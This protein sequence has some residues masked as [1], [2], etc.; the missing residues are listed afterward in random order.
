MKL[1]KLLEGIEYTGN[2]PDADITEV[3]CNSQIAQEGSAFVC[4]QGTKDD[5]HMHVRDALERGASVVVCARDTG[6]ENQVVV[7]DTREAY[8]VMCANLNGNPARKLKLIGVTGTNGKTT[9]TY[10]LKHILQEAGYRVGV[11]GTIH[12]E[13]GDIVLPAKH[14]TPDPAQ[15]HVLFSRMLKAG[16]QYVVME[17]SSHALDQERLTGCRFEAGIFTNLT[18]DHLDYHGTMENYFAAK[19]KLFDMSRIAVVNL[20]DPYGRRIADE[21]RG[22]CRVYT[23][24]ITDDQADFTAKDIRSHAGGSRFSLLHA[25]G[26]ERIRFCMPGDFSV[27]N[28]TAAAGCGAALGIPMEKVAAGLCSCEGVRGRTEVLPTNT[29]YT[30]ICDYAHSPDGLLKVITTFR[31]FAKGRVVTLF[32]CAGNRDR[33]KRAKMADIVAENSD[34]VILTSDNPRDEDPMQIIGDAMPGLE[35]HKTPCKILPDRFEAIEWALE[36]SRKDDILILAGKGH[37]DY[38]VLNYGTI[39]FDEH[40][41]VLDLLNRMRQKEKPSG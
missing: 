4:I 6:V 15:L 3:T 35:K 20:D 12:N 32:G 26:L 29:D 8:A 34:F 23:F 18:Q 1:S 16:C 10:L 27:S 30:V 24:S 28:A 7:K 31:Q 2:T 13:I 41:I 25:G 19:K 5:G 38:Q 33:T 11:I 21:Y 17:A 37:E 14:T 36:N 9:I 22:R 39:Y 40:R